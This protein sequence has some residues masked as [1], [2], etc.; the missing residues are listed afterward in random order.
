MP[1]TITAGQGPVTPAVSPT[2][3]IMVD[4]T[5]TADTTEI[6]AGY[7]ASLDVSAG[8]VSA[9]CGASDIAYGMFSSD[10]NTLYGRTS[11]GEFNAVRPNCELAGRYTIRQAVYPDSSGNELTA[12][13]ITNED[14][15]AS[16]WSTVA[17]G[18]ILAAVLNTS[19]IS[20][21][22]FNGKSMLRWVP[23]AASGAGYAAVASVVSKSEDGTE[24]EI[25]L[26]GHAQAYDADLSS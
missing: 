4:S 3:R 10:I 2:A 1:P 22:A 7:P 25:V 6:A 18:D 21:D 5:K 20:G 26:T 24:V 9:Q 11:L 16:E 23:N 12:Y 19:S 13:P 14:A 8:L 17:V 15:S